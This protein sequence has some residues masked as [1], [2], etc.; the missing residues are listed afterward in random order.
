M[1]K[2]GR[3]CGLSAAILVLTGRG[4][5]NAGGVGSE[6]APSAGGVTEAR[7]L[8]ADSDAANWLTHGPV[9]GFSHFS[10]RLNGMPLIG[11]CQNAADHPPL[12]NP[13]PMRF[14]AGS[15]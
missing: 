11:H 2:A 12:L 8:G 7:L 4:D 3:F 5:R 1:I 10:P 15:G 9:R 6:P 13:Y 14:F